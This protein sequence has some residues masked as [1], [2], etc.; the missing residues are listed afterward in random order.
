MTLFISTRG[1]NDKLNFEDVMLRGL[2][3]D[4][5]LYIP[6]E[7][8]TLSMD[9]WRSLVGKP[10]TEVAFAVISPFVG[11]CIPKDELKAMIEAAY[12]SFSHK[13]ITPLSQLDANLW[14][15]ELY[16]GP[17]IAFKDVAMQ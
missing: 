5:G 1:N 15:L 14:L 12:A 11:D 9:K 3:P 6:V 8:P 10:Y 16:H 13:A 2:A 17:T 4:G 7:W